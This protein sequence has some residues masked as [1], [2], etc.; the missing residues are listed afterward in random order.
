MKLFDY[1]LIVL[2]F[3]FLCYLIL[4]VGIANE[5]RIDAI[6]PTINQTINYYNETKIFND[7]HEVINKHYYNYTTIVE[8]KKDINFERRKYRECKKTA[9]QRTL[10]EGMSMFPFLSPEDL[11]W[12]EEVKYSDIEIGDVIVFEQD[13]TFIVHAVTNKYSDYL[14]TA[15]YNNDFEEVVYPEQIKWRYCEK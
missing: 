9:H 14:F 2:M 8:N 13:E 1:I 15:G 12:E 11:Y 7:S 4:F 3:F 10:S 5:N 6:Q